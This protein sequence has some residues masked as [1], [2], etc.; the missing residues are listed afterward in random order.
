M[1][2]TTS[3]VFDSEYSINLNLQFKKENL[4]EIDP[5]SKYKITVENAGE[6]NIITMSEK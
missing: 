5:Q 1:S 6:E 2:K 4:I 3:T